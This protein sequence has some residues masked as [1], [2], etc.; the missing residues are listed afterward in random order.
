MAVMEAIT[1][2]GA[3]AIMATTTATGS[4]PYGK[5]GF[6]RSVRYLLLPAAE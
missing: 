2:K 4:R 3:I 6:H 5:F 1:I